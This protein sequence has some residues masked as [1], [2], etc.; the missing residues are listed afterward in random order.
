MRFAETNLV[1]LVPYLDEAAYQRYARHCVKC[2][3]CKTPQATAPGGLCRTG[4]YLASALLIPR[5]AKESW[6]AYQNRVAGKGQRNR[7]R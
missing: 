7:T 2:P 1:R 4:R 5:T 3:I 6:S